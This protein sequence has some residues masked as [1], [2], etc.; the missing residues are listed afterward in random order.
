M[1]RVGSGEGGGKPSWNKGPW[2]NRRSR[3]LFNMGN[4]LR[5]PMINFGHEGSMATI[6]S[7][8]GLGQQVSLLRFLMAP[9]FSVR[10]SLA[11]P[12]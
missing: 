5:Q 10:C 2:Y 6:W 4:H 12:I 8:D 1:E 9:S 11:P 3:P 7:L